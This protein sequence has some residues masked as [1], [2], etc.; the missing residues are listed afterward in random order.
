MIPDSLQDDHSVTLLGKK[1]SSSNSPDIKTLPLLKVHFN[2]RERI[3]AFTFIETGST[4]E[5]V[6]CSF[7]SSRVTGIIILM[8]I[9]Y[10]C[11]IIILVLE[12]IFRYF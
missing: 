5:D 6:L 1:N 3:Y 11:I 7:C 8:H 10:K 9:K 4:L 12:A 2:V